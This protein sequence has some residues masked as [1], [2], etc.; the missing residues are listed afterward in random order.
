MRP[1]GSVPQEPPPGAPQWPSNHTQ[2]QAICIPNQSL[3]FFNFLISGKSSE[4][5]DE[6]LECLLTDAIHTLLGDTEVDG[7]LAVRQEISTLLKLITRP[8]GEMDLSWSYS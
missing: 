5:M 1:Q 3:I 2:A 4:V 7:R 6:P 8:Q